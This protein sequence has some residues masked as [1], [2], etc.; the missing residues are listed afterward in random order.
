MRLLVID[1]NQKYTEAYLL[2]SDTHTVPLEKHT[3]NRIF[4]FKKLEY[5]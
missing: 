1:N 2:V 4:F 5:S 3:L